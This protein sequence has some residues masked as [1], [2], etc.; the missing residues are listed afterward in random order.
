MVVPINLLQLMIEDPSVYEQ[1]LKCLPKLQEE[2]IE[3]VLEKALAGLETDSYEHNLCRSRLR[4]RIDCLPYS[5]KLYRSIG[6]LSEYD[7][8]SWLIVEGTVVR[9]SQRKTLEKSKVYKCTHCGFATRLSSTY[10]NNYTFVLPSKC[11]NPTDKP[12]NN[13]NTYFNKFFHKKGKKDSK[14]SED[15]DDRAVEVNKPKL[16]KCGCR[17]FEP[18][19]DQ[20][21][22]L[23]YQELK[24][25]E[26]FRHM[27]S[28][29]MPQSITVVIEGESLIDSCRP[30]DDVFVSG[31]VTYRYDKFA[32]ERVATGDIILVS[33]NIVTKK[34]KNFRENQEFSDTMSQLSVVIAEHSLY[35]EEMRVEK[36]LKLRQ[37]VIDLFC[38]NLYNRDLVKLGV[39]LCLLGGVSQTTHNTRIRGQSHLLLVGEPGTGKSVV[40]QAAA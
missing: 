21:I 2:F 24:L 29:K 23:D 38:P 17:T 28:G 30:G 1:L 11:T 15:D 5:P 18:S 26:P 13:G 25:Q 19:E 22:F 40:L 3:K 33:N 12:N 20:R 39:L 35:S 32:K 10:H 37:D 6:S 31:L 8:D 4:I 14:K 36:E 34:R 27:V 16:R 9:L 7:L